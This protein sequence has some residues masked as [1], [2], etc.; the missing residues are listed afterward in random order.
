MTRGCRRVVE[1]LT[2]NRS[3]A[4]CAAPLRRARRRAGVEAGV[5]RTMDGLGAARRERSF[6]TLPDGRR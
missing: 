6:L 2:R 4:R 1:D 5:P 3:S